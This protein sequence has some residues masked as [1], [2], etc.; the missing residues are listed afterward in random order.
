MSWHYHLLWRDFQEVCLRAKS[1][2]QKSL[3]NIIPL[4]QNE[5][6]TSHLPPKKL[7]A[8]VFIY[9]YVSKQKDKKEYVLDS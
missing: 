7:G 1:S 2:V 3:F 4:I 5:L 8:F 9:K 6:W